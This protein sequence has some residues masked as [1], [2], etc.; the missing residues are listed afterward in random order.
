[1][2][3]NILIQLIAASSNVNR[4][5]KYPLNEDMMMMGWDSK[6]KE[7]RTVRLWSTFYSWSDKEI[8]TKIWYE[9]K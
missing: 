5:D 8:S 3:E 2:L 4:V 6:N 7:L 9:K 1:M